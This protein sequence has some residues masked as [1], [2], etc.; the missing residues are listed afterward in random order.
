MKKLRQIEL[1]LE[2]CGQEANPTQYKSRN[3]GWLRNA[4]RGSRSYEAS[5]RSDQL[6]QF[7][8][9]FLSRIL[10]FRQTRALRSMLSK[11]NFQCI[12]VNRQDP[13]MRPFSKVSK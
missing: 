9:D 12:F 6:L 1:S 4:G 10:Q 7:P 5:L 8:M 11:D 2:T 3:Q 13:D